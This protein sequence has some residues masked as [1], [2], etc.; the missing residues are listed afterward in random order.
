MSALSTERAAA[1]VV[2]ALNGAALGVTFTR[3]RWPKYALKDLATTKAHV[4][5][6][7]PARM[8]AIDDAAGTATETPIAITLDAQCE[9]TNA[10]KID[11]LT[12]LLE[13][14][15]AVLAATNID[16]LGYPIEPLT[17]DR[18]EEA[19][20]QGQFCGGVGVVYRRYRD[21]EGLA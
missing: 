10:T 11:E 4:V 18:N 15:A 6:V 1:A 5:P 7:W 13:Q 9:K 14:I 12:D 21:G 8:E 2:T 17:I 16:D 20:D 19:L 3:A